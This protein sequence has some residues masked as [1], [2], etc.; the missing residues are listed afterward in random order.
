M[1]DNFCSFLF[2]L[3][4]PE[5]GFSLMDL[6]APCRKKKKKQNPPRRG[7]IQQLCEVLGIPNIAFHNLPSKRKRQEGVQRGS[8]DDKRIVSLVK[9]I[10]SS[11]AHLLYPHRPERLLSQELVIAPSPVKL[12]DTVCDFCENAPK[13]SV[14]RR[15]ARAIAVQ[16][17]SRQTIEELSQTRGLSKT[18]LKGR[19]RDKA[20][21]DFEAIHSGKDLVKV[22]WARS[23]TSTEVVEK[24]VRFLL[25]PS[26]ISPLSW[27]TRTVRL[28][29]S[30]EVELPRLCAHR[31]T[32][33]S[34][35][36]YESTVAE[37][38]LKR[39][40][41][42]KLSNSILTQK[43]KL[44]R[45]VDYVSGILLHEPIEA[46]QDVID[47][48][49]P[50]TQKKEMTKDLQLARNFLKVQYDNHVLKEGDGVRTHGIQFGLSRPRADIPDRDG[51]C[52]AC[53]FPFHV[54]TKV[55]QLVGDCDANTL[56]TNGGEAAKQ[57]A[58]KMLDDVFEK[59]HLYQGHRA[60]VVNQNLA[61]EKALRNLEHQ[62]SLGDSS[63][64]L[65]VIDW[66]MKFEAL[67]SRETTQEHFGKRGLPWHGAMIFHFRREVVDGKVVTRPYHIYV[68]Q[69]MHGYSKQSA[70]ATVSMLESALTWI[71]ANLPGVN[72]IILQSDNAKNYNTNIFKVAIGLLNLYMPIQVIR[73][74]HSGVQAGKCLI[75]AHFACASK[76]VAR[77]V[78]KSDGKQ[79]AVNRVRSVATA[80]GLAHVLMQPGLRNHG[81]QLVTIDPSKLQAVKD[82]VGGA[83]K[84]LQRFFSACS[85]VT[86]LDAP[87]RF[88]SMRE[89][90]AAMA[91][92]NGVAFDIQAQLHSGIDGAR[93]NI[94][95]KLEGGVCKPSVRRVHNN[96][97]NGSTSDNDNDGQ[98]DDDDNDGDD[99]DNDDGGEDWGEDVMD[100]R[101]VFQNLRERAEYERREDAAAEIGMY[102]CQRLCLGVCLF[103]IVSVLSVCVSVV[104]MM[105]IT[106]MPPTTT[107]TETTTATATMTMTMVTR[108]VPGRCL[109]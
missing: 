27:G 66:K 13:N 54:V 43:P 91:S 7:D 86:Y 25:S 73:Y 108:R 8:E 85:D 74:I 97:N 15:V 96:E 40:T 83:A 42:F 23:R 92:G 55:K 51:Q 70:E 49:L 75:D 62:A 103:A 44:L 11:T 53:S 71:H 35:K 50:R 61:I 60:R 65:M 94:V 88:S 107:T 89:L 10:H 14:A 29:K 46:V 90:R 21:A 3:R 77:I 26:N 16:S 32:Q 18:L 63:T 69:I 57:D 58:L 82:L 104:K 33:A 84:L 4:R 109:P 20:K 41:F 30:E 64:V 28:S 100:M 22:K 5:H 98:S 6:I 101:G 93:F 68:D 59:M 31:T 106:T 95:L 76:H 9:K 24:T 36:H 45:A 2:F 105:T 48:F 79:G 47:V 67:S 72:K 80:R 1:A 99:N 17:F 12:I 34:F 39:T 56:L 19:A 78:A 37:P 52:E 81:V 38:R 87:R 102:L